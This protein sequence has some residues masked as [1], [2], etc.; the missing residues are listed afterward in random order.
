MVEERCMKVFRASIKTK[1]TEENYLNC[2]KYFKD[3]GK[4][5]KY[6]DILKLKPKKLTR[7]IEDYI[8]FR[9]EKK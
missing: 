5:N 8:V 3:F 6:R 4:F 7:L 9:R 2:M 1:S